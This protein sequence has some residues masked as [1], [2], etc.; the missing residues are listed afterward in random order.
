VIDSELTLSYASAVHT[1]ASSAFIDF[2]NSVMDRKFSEF[3]TT[4]INV[5]FLY[6][7]LKLLQF[8]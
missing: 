7:A 5:N 6:S 4:E 1:T 2:G 3:S 8:P